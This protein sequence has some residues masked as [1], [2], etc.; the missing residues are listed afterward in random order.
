MSSLKRLV[1]EVHRRS[2]WQVLL[3]YVGAGWAC[4]ELIDAVTNRLGLPAWLP[5]LAIVLFLLA[6]PVVVATAFIQDSG[7]AA[8][9]SDPT[10]IP[11]DEARTE[12]ARRRRFLTWRNAGLSFLVALALWGVVAA[13]LLSFGGRVEP[14][15]ERKM[16]VVLPF[17]NLG[18]PEDGYFA[19]GITDAIN[20]RLAAISGLGVISRQ[21]AYTYKGS[22]KTAPEIGDELGVDF[23]LEGTV[24]RE[25]H[26]DLYEKRGDTTNAIRYY[27][28]FVDLWKD[29]DPELQPRVE[30]ARRAMEALWT[31]R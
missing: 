1:V 14:S 6:L 5:G 4:F 17:E 19:D 25:R 22:N 26:G 30:A 27:A 9:I 3:I 18:A 23:I 24:Q 13:G 2:L 15:V 10:L 21:S 8:T 12:A 11:V 29:A 16:L 28:K 31:D 20:A 7:P